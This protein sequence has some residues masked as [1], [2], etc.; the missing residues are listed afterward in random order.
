MH[1]RK[2]PHMIGSY[3]SQWKNSNQKEKSDIA[4]RISLRLHLFVACQFKQ[5]TVSMAPNITTMVYCKE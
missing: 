1:Q 4:V 3:S 5:T 2:V